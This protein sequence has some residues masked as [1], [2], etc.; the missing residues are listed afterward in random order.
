MKKLLA[1]ITVL[2]SAGLSACSAK[3]NPGEFNFTTDEISVK[4]GY[5]AE[6][7]IFL[8]NINLDDLD[9]T[10]SNSEIASISGLFLTGNKIGETTLTVTSL[11]VPEFS[12]V[13]TV[14]V[15]QVKPDFNITE[16]VYEIDE[17]IQVRLTNFNYKD[18]TWSVNNP[19]VGILDEYNYFIALD[20]GEVTITA[21]SKSDSSIFN[22]YTIS[23][24]EKRPTLLAT[25]TAFQVD[26]KVQIYLKDYHN[27]TVDDYL[28]SVSDN[29]IL[30]IDES[31]V[32]T[33]LK[34]GKA[35]VQATLKNDPRVISTLPLIVGKPS[36]LKDENG[37]PNDGP[38]II[39]GMNA[40]ATVQ[41]GETLQY[42]VA[43][44]VDLY[45]YKWDSDDTPIVQVT[46]E[47]VIYGVKEGQTKV[48]V[49]LKS[50]LRNRTEII[51][52]VVGTPNVD[53]RSRI[54]A[55]ALG[56]EPYK[57]G[58]GKDNKY[59]E[60]YPYNNADWCAIFVS[61]A[62]NQ[63]GVSTDV[64]TKFSYCPA[65]WT[66]FEENATTYLRGEYTP[67]PGDIIFFQNNDDGILTHVGIVVEAHDGYIETI[68]GNTSGVLGSGSV[69]TK[70]RYLSGT[71]IY[72]YA[73][74]N[75]PEYTK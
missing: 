4:I 31:L 44:S 50:N 67:K 74:P 29:S 75:Y 70:A 69:S 17:K 13:L 34:D 49:A 61:W 21:T 23:V 54:V 73:V 39:T 63:A 37:E 65:G 71:Y 8:N 40:T 66:W 42:Q 62:A 6:L 64:I 68:E 9:F 72:G 26:D 16:N 1:L 56:E 25:T 28:W 57:E 53:Y 11:L 18:F 10:W 15:T 5:V 2:L 14:K 59:G 32:V 60:W 33:G 27:Y 3:I 22:T 38:I 12:D 47:G 46:D 48:T 51:V 43:G 36:T 24:I 52:N 20:K 45:N 19:T 30:A 41:A 35:E 7:P 58:P 55:A